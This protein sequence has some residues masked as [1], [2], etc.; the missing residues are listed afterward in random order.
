MVIMKALMSKAA[1][2][3]PRHRARV[4]LLDRASH[5]ELITERDAWELIETNHCVD[6]SYLQQLLFFF[7]EQSG[8]GISALSQ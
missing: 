8:V 6:I 4:M 1:N 7:L 3:R 5:R 2:V